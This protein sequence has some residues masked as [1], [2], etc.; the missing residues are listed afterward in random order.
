M[1]H[2]LP[3]GHFLSPLCPRLAVLILTCVS[4]GV[5]TE[6]PTRTPTQTSKDTR[7]A[8]GFDA[9]ADGV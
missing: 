4:V 2:W 3:D 8:P 6:T 9:P 5:I 7:A 1:P